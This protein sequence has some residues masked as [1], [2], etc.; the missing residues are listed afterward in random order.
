MIHDLS[1]DGNFVAIKRAA[2][3][4]EVYGDTKKGCQKPTVQQKTTD[5]DG[6]YEGDRGWLSHKFV[7]TSAI[8][9]P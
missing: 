3:D 8:T 9:V 2:E 6:C 4:R 7:V 1:N 5:D